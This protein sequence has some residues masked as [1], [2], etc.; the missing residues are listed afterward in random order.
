MSTENPAVTAEQQ[1]EEISWYKFSAGPWLTDFFL[2]LTALA[3]WKWHYIEGWVFW[4]AQILIFI[5]FAL[6]AGGKLQLEKEGKKVRRGRFASL[7]KFVLFLAAIYVSY[8]LYPDLPTVIKILITVPLS[9]LYVFYLTILH[10]ASYGDY[11]WDLNSG[12]QTAD[13]GRLSHEEAGDLNDLRIIGLENEIE[14]INGRVDTY[15]LESALFGALT[16]SGFLALIVA[17]R[18]QI[19]AFAQLLD[20]F[21]LLWDKLVSL[22]FHAIPDFILSLDRTMLLNLLVLESLI[23]TLLFLSVIASRLRFSDSIEHIHLHVRAARTFKDKE[24]EILN[25]LLENEDMSPSR[26]M[27]YRLKKLN[28]KIESNVSEAS[29][30]LERLR[31]VTV[32]MKVFRT[33]GMMVFLLTAITGSLLISKGLAV[34]FAVVSVAAFLYSNIEHSLRINHFRAGALLDTAYRFRHLAR[35]GNIQLAERRK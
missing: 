17:D 34:I 32:Y 27:E 8:H 30:K 33:A 19:D 12:V 20:K 18:V 7:L 31:P 28:R 21:G 22:Q 13:A 10:D 25:F 3:L 1:E 14:A 24:E 16:F 2:R 15:I 35:K 11:I 6:W 29:S 23:C 4:S 5:V 9:L 26:R